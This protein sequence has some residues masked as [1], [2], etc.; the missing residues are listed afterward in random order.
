[1]A[2]SARALFAADGSWNVNA[3]GNWATA[4]NPPWVGGIVPGSTSTTNN[5]DTALFDFTLTSGRAVTVDA[6]RNI[7]VISFGNSGA[8]G[9]TLGTGNLL[10]SNGG[11]IQTLSG[12]GNHTDVVSAAIAIQGIGGTASFTAGA[13][14][15][16]SLLSI[17]GAVTG[18][19]TAGNTTIL[20]LNGSNTGFNSIGSISN[21]SAGGKLAVVKEG[22]GTWQLG[23]GGT[24]TGGLTLNDGVI[25]IVAGSNGLLGPSGGAFTMN[26]GELL[27]ATGVGRIQ[28][29][30]ATVGGNATITSDGGS[31]GV[32]VTHGLT[33]LSIGAHTLTIQGGTN[34]TSG[35]AGFSITGA[36]T[37][38]GAA[39]FN[40]LNNGSSATVLTLGSIA[41]NVDNGGHLLTLT[42]NGSSIVKNVLSGSGGLS[43]SGSGMLTLSSSNSYSG[44]TTVEAGTLLLGSGAS[45]ANS[46]LV[47]VKAGATLDATAVAGGFQLESG[48]ALQ[49]SGTFSGA[50]TAK[51]GSIY[52]PGNSPG[53][54][55]QSGN[56]ALNTGSTF[57]WDLVAN[58]TA[59]PGINFDQTQFTSGGLTIESGVAASLIFNYA[60]SVVDWTNVFWDSDHSWTLFSGASSLS[61][62]A[63]VFGTVFVGVDSFGQNF[64]IT[65]GTFSFSTSGNDVILN[66][67]AV[68]EPGT[69]ALLAVAGLV[70]A[71]RFRCRT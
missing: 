61:T 34:I 41:G 28:A 17:T 37:L 25:R 43:K 67:G 54:A 70:F 24:Y 8:A 7:G 15:A 5:A 50:L 1:M 19:S 47:R 56:L 45:I 39:T 51:A 36:T 26:G 49:N 10:L 3:A 53:V 6:N 38:T 21:G 9:Y 4:A 44:V 59:S 63:S 18:V 64:S 11:V 52:A 57:Q 42:G 31:G 46:S 66:Y 13:S 33:T 12:N 68:P 55:T 27:M 16:S 58:S 69:W 35:T 32:G 29:V 71:R 40:V 22:S 30:A 23:A 14:S 48:Q 20:T 65:G 2:M 62:V 60:G